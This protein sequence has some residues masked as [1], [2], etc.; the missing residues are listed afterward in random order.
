[1]NDFDDPCLD[2]LGDQYFG[3]IFAEVPNL[4]KVRAYKERLCDYI[5]WCLRNG[6]WEKTQEQHRRPNLEVITNDGPVRPNPRRMSSPLK[7]DEIRAFERRVGRIFGIR[8]SAMMEW[9]ASRS[10][11]T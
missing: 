6:L 2:R 7:T 1:M 8:A 11:R 9:T 5:V 4:A 10:Q 3:E